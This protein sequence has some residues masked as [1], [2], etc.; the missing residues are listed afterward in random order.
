MNIDGEGRLLVAAPR[1]GVAVRVG[2]PVLARKW[3]EASNVAQVSIGR[4]ESVS[5]PGRWR[6]GFP[7]P[8]THSLAE[9]SLSRR[10]EG[11]GRAARRPDP[12]SSPTTE[13]RPVMIRF[14]Y[15]ALRIRNDINA[16]RRG[17]VGR[18]IGR[19][20]YGKATGRLAARIFG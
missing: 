15:R 9:A 1:T 2:L 3:G 6:P 10:H 12:S 17:R 5:I 7:R 8:G 16:V 19:R 14:L 4:G 18:R 13:R 20:I 11:S